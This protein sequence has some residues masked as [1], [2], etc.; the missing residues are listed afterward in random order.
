MLKELK[1]RLLIR[2]S[3]FY[4][5]SMRVPKTVSIFLLGIDVKSMVCSRRN[6]FVSEKN[7]FCDSQQK[8]ASLEV[9]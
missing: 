5:V 4:S 8:H 6:C 9:T 3:L 2:T 1:S 7:V